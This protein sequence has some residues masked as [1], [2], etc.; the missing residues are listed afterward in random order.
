[1]MRSLQLSIRATS[2][3][4]TGVNS[5]MMRKIAA[6]ARR[7]DNIVMGMAGLLGRAENA[8]LTKANPT[9]SRIKMRP[10]PGQPPAKVEYK[11]RN[12][13]TSQTINF[14]EYRKELEPQE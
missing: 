12:G 3:P 13:R 10:N 11:R 14:R 5:P 2:V 9:T 8:L 6:A 4:T 1:M 7:T